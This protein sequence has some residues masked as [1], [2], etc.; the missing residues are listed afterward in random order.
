MGHRVATVELLPAVAV[1]EVEL[2]PVLVE[3]E[4]L[5]VLM[6]LVVDAT[7][8]SSACN[9]GC[10]FRI[11]CSRSSSCSTQPELWAQVVAEV[12]GGSWRRVLQLQKSGQHSSE[13]R[14]SHV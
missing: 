2:P 4:L 3:V 10:G 1:A 12:G 8:G 14:T 9:I 11:S 6:V 5:L 7:A 13:F